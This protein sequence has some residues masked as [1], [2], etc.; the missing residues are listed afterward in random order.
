MSGYSDDVKRLARRYARHL[1]IYNA[2]LEALEDDKPRDF[3][4][5]CVMRRK[6]YSADAYVNRAAQDLALL[7][8]TE[9][10]L[11]IGRYC[12]EEA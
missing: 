4:E 6:Y 10:D 3:D 8:A 5:L 2:W 11:N 7:V 12:V 1:K 9:L